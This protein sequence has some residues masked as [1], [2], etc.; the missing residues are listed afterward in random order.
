[1]A[2]LIR[3]PI[4][5]LEPAYQKPAAGLVSQITLENRRDRRLNRQ[6]TVKSQTE[7]ELLVIS[8]A[9]AASVRA[10]SI[11]FLRRKTNWCRA[12]LPSH[13][14]SGRLPLR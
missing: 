4:L 7:M 2:L 8:A 11:T 14:F 5:A 12:S 9:R 6:G 1:M 10:L 13:R 3:W